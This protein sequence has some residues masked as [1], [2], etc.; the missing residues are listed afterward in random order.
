M[1]VR[2]LSFV[3]LCAGAL[4][5]SPAHAGKKP[6]IEPTE[7][8]VA[9]VV[10]RLDAG[11][12]KNE[13]FFHLCD[14]LPSPYC[15]GY[16]IAHRSTS[17]FRTK[18]V[19]GSAFPKPVDNG[20]PVE[21]VVRADRPL[22]FEVSSRGFYVC[23]GDYRFQPADGGR[24]EILFKTTFDACRTEVVRLIETAD[25]AQAREAVPDFCR[26]GSGGECVSAP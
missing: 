22:I 6:Y 25:G 21:V 19:A 18:P 8:P 14:A 4:S 10:F 15:E 20:L 13:I 9:K 2:T 3:A 17:L 1:N 11:R 23:G 7:G 24:Y 26:L 5:A 16:T 12:P